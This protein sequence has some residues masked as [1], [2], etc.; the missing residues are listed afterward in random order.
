MGHGPDFKYRISTLKI[1]TMGQGLWGTMEG[2]HLTV[3]DTKN[4]KGN[5]KYF[6]YYLPQ[7]AGVS[8]QYC[9]VVFP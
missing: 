1:F 6:G 8:P 3:D 7:C 4:I 5:Y 2:Y 9:W